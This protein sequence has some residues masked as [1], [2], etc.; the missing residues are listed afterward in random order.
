M[1]C[2]RLFLWDW[3]NLSQ[4]FFPAPRFQHLKSSL[5]YDVKAVV[6]VRQGLA[7]EVKKKVPDFVEVRAALTNEQEAA[8]TVLKCYATEKILSENC[9]YSRPE[10]V[11]L[12]YGTEKGYKELIAQLENVK[13]KVT[14]VDG[15]TQTMAGVLSEYS[16]QY[17]QIIFSNDWD[18]KSHVQVQPCGQCRKPFRCR[19]EEKAEEKLHRQQHDYCRQIGCWGRYCG[20]DLKHLP[21]T[22]S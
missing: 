21:K 12:V 20:D 22:L 9:R 13:V 6:F 15:R 3:E 5:P 16:C 10:S 17:C 4:N 7:E 14:Y 19:E 2:K 1:S 8:D 18:A 11:F